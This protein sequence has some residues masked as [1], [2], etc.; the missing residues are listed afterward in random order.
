M[1]IPL[2]GPEMKS[3]GEVMGIGRISGRPMPRRSWV[4]ASACPCPGTVFISVGDDDKAAMLAVARAVCGHGIFDSGHRRHLVPLPPAV[5]RPNGST[6][7]SQGRPHAADAIKNGSIQLIINT[8]TGDEPRRDGYVI[9]RAALK[10]KV[11]YATTTRRCAGRMPGHCR[12][13]RKAFS[14]K[15]VQDTIG[16]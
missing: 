7:V 16:N 4:P 5:S 3:T 12:A 14:V 10:F 9:R 8:G 6:K 13:Q 15:P 11:P 2:L 1:W